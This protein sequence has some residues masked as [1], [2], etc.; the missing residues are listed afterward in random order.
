MIMNIVS[1]NKTQTVEN[2]PYGRLRTSVTFSIEFKPKKGFRSVFQSINPKNGRLNSPKNST[3]NNFMW[4]TNE[5]GFVK[6]HGMNFRSTKD[7]LRCSKFISENF[8]K[9][10][11]TQEQIKEIFLLMYQTV[12]IDISFSK[13]ENPNIVEEFKPL[14]KILIDGSN[15]NNRFSD[16]VREIE[17]LN[18]SLTK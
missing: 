14:L 6:T 2:Y 13:R 1:V 3:Y 17:N 10:E 15:G 8:D 12:V 18:N 16:V 7:I 11:L 5:N 9:F 4:M